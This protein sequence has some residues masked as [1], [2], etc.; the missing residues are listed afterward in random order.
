[1][2]TEQIDRLL[3]KAEDISG[4][5]NEFYSLAKMEYMKAGGDPVSIKASPATA[6]P[7]KQKYLS[8]QFIAMAASK[9]V[10]T[11]EEAREISLKESQSL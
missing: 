1:M 9:L 4:N 6:L 2:T 3:A 11:I 5:A 7:F 8:A 10:R